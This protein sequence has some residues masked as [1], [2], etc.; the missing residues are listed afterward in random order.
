M[1]LRGFRELLLKGNEADHRS[2][3]PR[4]EGGEPWK[5]PNVLLV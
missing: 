4:D 1:V 5:T 2:F 3:E